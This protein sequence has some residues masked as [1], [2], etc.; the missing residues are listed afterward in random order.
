MFFRT[1]STGFHFLFLNEGIL[2]IL[3]DC[4]IVLSPFLDVTRMSI[5]TV[6]YLAQLD[7]GI[8]CLGNGFP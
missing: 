3:I 8:L 6:T 4:M 1:G 7:S 5:S 2:V